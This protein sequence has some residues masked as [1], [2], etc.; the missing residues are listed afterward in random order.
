M[1]K[2]TLNSEC[3]LFALIMHGIIPVEE[4]RRAFLEIVAHP[5]FDPEI[6]IYVDIRAVT[7][8][9][10]DF[11]RVFMAVQAVKAEM[12]HFGDMSC[13]V[14]LAGD[15]SAYGMARMLQQ[16]VEAVAR[17]RMRVV[18]SMGEASALLGLSAE[19]LETVSGAGVES[20]IVGSS[21]E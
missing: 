7:E 5:G 8:V 6:P 1:Y 18:A 11:P 20:L 4:G 15:G 16:V 19:I 13:M 12:R 14:I 10:A 17:L 3:R 2:L 21:G 9:D